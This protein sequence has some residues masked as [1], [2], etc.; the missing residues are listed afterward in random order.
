MKYAALLLTVLACAAA[1]SVAQTYPARPITLIVPFPA[2][3]VIDLTARAI[4]ARLGAGLGQSIVVDSRAGASGT[5][6]AD[7]VAKAAPDGYTL[8]Y[9]TGSALTT[10][11]LLIR[12]LPY[13]PVKSFAPVSL[14]LYNSYLLAL[15]PAV[16]AQDV[17][18]FVAY[19]RAYPGNLGY[20][21][22][23]VGGGFHLTI[24]MFAAAAGIQML[25]VPFK[26]GGPAAIATIAGDTQLTI[27]A[28]AALLQ[29]VKAGKLR[30]LAVTS[31]RRL[32]IL[33]GVPALAETYPGFESGFWNGVLA[34]AGTPRAAIERLAVDLK[35]AMASAEIID[36]L[37]RQG[38]SATYQPPEL[39]AAYMQGESAK[40]GAI[41][42]QAGIKPE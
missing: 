20:A 8:L 31:T 38:A 1:P 28:P 17:R 14:L 23:G 18:Q 39:F 33:P 27:D 35:K 42:R 3:G 16:P 24:E 7:A 34:P 13:D 29:H 5:I 37:T 15:N 12:N 40:W 2:G 26:G 4:A 41:V 10:A 19:A 6:A 30:A 36:N 25:H 11:P 32:A 9:A 22:N 21:S